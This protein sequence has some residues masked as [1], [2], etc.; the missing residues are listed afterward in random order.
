MKIKDIQK[1]LYEGKKAL[2]EEQ[3]Q[4]LLSLER[5]QGPFYKQS[6][7]LKGNGDDEDTLMIRYLLLI[8]GR[9]ALIIYPDSL[10][11]ENKNVTPAAFTLG[12]VIPIG[13]EAFTNVIDE[14]A[15]ELESARSCGEEFEDPTKV[16]SNDFIQNIYDFIANRREVKRLYNEISF[17]RVSFEKPIEEEEP[18]P[19]ETYEEKDDGGEEE[20]FTF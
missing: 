20:I 8:N 4:I 17:S 1:T 6:Y 11:M 3:R 9:I 18:E 10:Q 12:D 7:V 5:R 15:S 19:T 2:A 16:P 13:E 14:F